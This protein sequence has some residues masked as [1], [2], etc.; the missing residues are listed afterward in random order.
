MSSITFLSLFV[1]RWVVNLFL[2]QSVE[3]RNAT[4]ESFGVCKPETDFTPLDISYAPTCF[5]ENPDTTREQ[6]KCFI[7][8]C[9]YCILFQ[10]GAQYMKVMQEAIFDNRNSISDCL[11]DVPYEQGGKKPMMAEME[12]L[13]RSEGGL[14]ETDE[15]RKEGLHSAPRRILESRRQK[16]LHHDG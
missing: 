14:L 5:P 1:T 12:F 16:A 15:G 11:E 2:V 9:F 4:Q 7:P 13:F 8:L 10:M 3:S 6:I